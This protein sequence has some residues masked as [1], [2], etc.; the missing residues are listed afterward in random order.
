MKQIIQRENV[1][2]LQTEHTAL[3]LQI[4]RYG[5]VELLHYGSPVSMGD[6]P[7]LSR[8]APCRTAVR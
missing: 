1:F 3:L 4:T 7:A 2:L 5:H 8:A 6:A